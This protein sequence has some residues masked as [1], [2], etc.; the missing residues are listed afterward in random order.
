M[1]MEAF[2]EALHKQLHTAHIFQT[3]YDDPYLEETLQEGCILNVINPVWH[4]NMTVLTALD[5]GHNSCVI[6]LHKCRYQP[7]SMGGWKN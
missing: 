5:S 7:R 1:T 2:S 4:I 6:L 3:F